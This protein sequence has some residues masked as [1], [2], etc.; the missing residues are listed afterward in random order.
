MRNAITNKTIY[1]VLWRE[2]IYEKEKIVGSKN[3]IDGS[4]PDLCTVH[5][6]LWI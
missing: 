2:N 6:S 5:V 1:L 4:M 3:S